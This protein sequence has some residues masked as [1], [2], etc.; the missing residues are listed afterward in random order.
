MGWF[1]VI[2][3]TLYLQAFIWYGR[4]SYVQGVL[5]RHYTPRSDRVR[6]VLR[7]GAGERLT[8]AAA[9]LEA[10]RTSR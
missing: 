9:A 2:V 1:D 3:L 5:D 7:S 6:N 8:G 10:Q 4:L